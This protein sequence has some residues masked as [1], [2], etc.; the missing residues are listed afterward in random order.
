MRV[1]LIATGERGADPA[2]LIAGRSLVLRQFDFARACG[3]ERVIAYGNGA[4]ADADELREAAARAQV[5][6]ATIASA[7]ALVPLIEWRDE[8]LVLAPGALP[9]AT[10]AIAALAEGPR[11]L[12][13]GVDEAGADRFERIDASEAWSGALLMPGALVDRLE[14][15]GEDADP[16]SALL[17]IAL[18]ERTARVRLSPDLLAQGRWAIVAEEGDTGALEARRQAAMGREPIGM[19]PSQQLAGLLLRR[20]SAPLIRWRYSLVALLAAAGLLLSSGPI[21]AWFGWPAAGFAVLALAV[22]L[23]HLARGLDR[24]RRAAFLKP[25]LPRWLA[26]L[27]DA[28]LLVTGALSIEGEWYARLFPPLVLVI[29]LAAISRSAGWRAV[30]GDRGLGALLVAVAALTGMQEP[31]LMAW[32]LAALAAALLGGRDWSAGGGDHRSSTGT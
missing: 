9:D 32:A 28:A 18:Q 14:Q 1:A 16:H 27:P 6:H 4:A 21:A 13:F 29:A 8:L 23:L 22:P 10:E 19:R 30:A 2:P 12:A 26:R 11:V 25:L 5:A 24:M 31:A 17:R 3:V 7:H 15:L 20:F